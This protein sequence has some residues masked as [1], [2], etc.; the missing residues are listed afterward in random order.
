VLVLIG[1]SYVVAHGALVHAWVLHAGPLGP[2]LSLALY[3]TVASVPFLP[4]GVLALLDGMIFGFWEGSII[5]CTAVL[6]SGFTTYAVARGIAEDFGVHDELERLPGWIR[7]L[8]MG[9]PAFLVALRAIPWLGGTLANNVGPMY[10]VSL[11][12]HSWTRAVVAMPL[13]IASAYLGWKFVP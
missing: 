1:G 2:L 6:L 3:T 10:G 7:R 13:A 5:S 8:P 4:S 12:R 11:W 9:S